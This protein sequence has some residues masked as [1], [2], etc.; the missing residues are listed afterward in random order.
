VF[1]TAIQDA[2]LDASWWD[3]IDKME[4]GVVT[5]RPTAV[6]NA[7]RGC[8][9]GNTHAGGKLEC[10]IRSTSRFRAQ[11]HIYCIYT[12]DYSASKPLRR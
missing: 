12:L 10:D 11:L 1:L 3:C 4:G 6:R 9:I 7:S 2:G 5:L 8:L